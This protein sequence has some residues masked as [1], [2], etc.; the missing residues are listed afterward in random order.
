[1]ENNH[2]YGFSFSMLIAEGELDTSSG[3]EEMVITE[4]ID[5]TESGAKGIEPFKVMGKL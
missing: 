3:A 1:V 2:K 4:G 5:S